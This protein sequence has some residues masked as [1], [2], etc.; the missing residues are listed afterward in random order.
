MQKMRQQ[1]QTRQKTKNGEIMTQEKI[2][3][4]IKIN[5]H[6]RFHNHLKRSHNRHNHNYTNRINK[7]N[8]QILKLSY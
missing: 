7:F 5:H 2:T 4:K 8:I 1:T 6:E 3:H